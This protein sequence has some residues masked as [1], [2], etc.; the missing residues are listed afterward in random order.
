MQEAE[1]SRMVAG[2]GQG[3]ARC[4]HGFVEAVRPLTVTVHGGHLVSLLK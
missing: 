1:S 4:A 3:Q 2:G